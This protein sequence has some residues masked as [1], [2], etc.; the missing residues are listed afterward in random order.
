MLYYS[1]ISRCLPLFSPF[2]LP[3]LSINRTYQAFSH[4]KFLILSL[5]LKCCSLF[6]RRIKK[7]IPR[8]CV[9]EWACTTITPTS[10]WDMCWLQSVRRLPSRTGVIFNLYLH[11]GNISSPPSGLSSVRQ[12]ACRQCLYSDH[13]H[14]Q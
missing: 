12:F 11:M 5:E 9:F 3:F 13:L 2:S 6:L 14:K 4:L 10:K 1:H 8:Q 7:L